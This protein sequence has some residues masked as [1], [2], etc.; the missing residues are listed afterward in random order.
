MR[1]E[2]LRGFRE[3]G[4]MKEKPERKKPQ[5]RTKEHKGKNGEWRIFSSSLFVRFVPFVVITLVFLACATPP[6]ALPPVHPSAALPSDGDAYFYLS[7][8]D[9]ADLLA[10]FTEADGK[11]TMG[12][13]Y[14]IEHSRR[15]YGAVSKNPAGSAFLIA[16]QGD[17]SVG[18][19][20]FGIGRDDAWEETSVLLAEGEQRYYHNRDTGMEIAIPSP[21]LILMG[22]GL[23]ERIAFLYA[24][25]PS[26]LPED[27]LA[28]LES[29]SAGFY[30]PKAAKTGLPPFIP[31]NSPLPLKE[32]T[33]FADPDAAGEG[34]VA[35]GSLLFAS[36]KDTM[37]AAFMLRLAFSSLMSAQGKSLTEIR[38]TLKLEVQGA[39]IQ[40]SGITLP[41]EMAREILFSLMA[42][43]KK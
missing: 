43:E 21:E 20:E 14:F 9:N 7:V 41:K 32:A 6:S 30:L 35:A 25:S 37:G 15:I 10:G 33:L 13:R 3:E 18:L 26:P 39:S 38:Q 22:N 8:A 34:Y 12:S 1:R 27:T 28:A 17:Y 19:V 40:F 24:G 2:A 31:A 5:S 11:S 29:H 36:D 4:R 16:A 23:A 42:G